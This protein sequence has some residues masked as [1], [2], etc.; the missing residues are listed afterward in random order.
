MNEK[1]VAGR[2]SAFAGALRRAGLR[3]THQRLEVVRELAKSE[4]HPDVE[5]IFSEVRRR[6]P[7]IS[8]DTVYRTVGT[9]VELGL[10]GRMSTAAG[11]VRY[12]ANTSLHHHFY[13]TRCGLIVD[14][15][16]ASL[17]GVQ[18]PE[19]A[20]LLGKVESFEIQLKG[21]CAECQR[22]E[23]GSKA[24]AGAAREEGTIEGRQ[25]PARLRSDC[26]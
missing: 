18:V 11:P 5:T 12:D 3:L 21:V 15:H 17:D 4:A 19:E 13:C 20:N 14:V 2:V 26:R 7:T 1:E 22:K 9:L 6:V 10:V 8:L 16:Y 24:R 23:A 25:D